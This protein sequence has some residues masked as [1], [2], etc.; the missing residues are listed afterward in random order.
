[1]RRKFDA[2]SGFTLVELL[3]VVIILAILAAIVVPQFS[4]SAN[5]AQFAA[6]QQNLSTIR[7]AIELYRVQ[8][9]GVYPGANA[10]TGGG[11]TCTGAAPAGAGGVAG[12]GAANNPQA[13]ID[14][15]TQ[16]TNLSGQS[17][18]V[19]ANGPTVGFKYGPYLRRSIP[20]EPLSS[21]STV[22]MNSPAG[23]AITPGTAGGWSYDSVTG[24]FIANNNAVNTN[25]STY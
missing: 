7:S 2:R 13:L 11:A 10:S 6:L 1:M 12:T 22:T 18:T 19:T 21:I 25:L 23:T 14:Q 3:I 8:H 5:D 17:C 9:N 20:A 4:T 15:L 24:Q 16:S